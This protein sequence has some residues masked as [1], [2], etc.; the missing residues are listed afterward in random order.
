MS[1]GLV[2]L[3][4]Q[5]HVMELE[6]MGSVKYYGRASESVFCPCCCVDQ[7]T[8]GESLLTAWRKDRHRVGVLS[9]PCW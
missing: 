3:R 2:M 1:S 5:L 4:L 6:W 7:V 9:F 8:V